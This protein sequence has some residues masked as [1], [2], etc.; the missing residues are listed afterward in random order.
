MLTFVKLAV[1][2]TCTSG[3]ALAIGLHSGMVG[4]MDNTNG[5]LLLCFVVC[6]WVADAWLGV[7]DD[8]TLSLAS[9]PTPTPT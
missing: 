5:S 7:Y 1:A 8:R 2:C 4:A 3:M 6:Y 9:T